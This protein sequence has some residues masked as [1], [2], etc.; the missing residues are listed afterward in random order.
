MRRITVLIFLA[1]GLPA[2]ACGENGSPLHGS[3]ASA[4][5]VR[6]ATAPSPADRITAGYPLGSGDAAV[7]VVEFSDFG[8]P[9]CGR[10]AVTTFPDLRAEYIETGRVRWRYVPV[11]FGFAGGAVMGAAAECAGR[12]AG[13]DGF[14]R[15]HDIMYRHQAALRG[16]DAL[17]RLLQWLGEAGLDAARIEACVQDPA[18]V[19]VLQANNRLAEEW[20]VR[21]TPTFVVN[22][23]PMSGAMPTS[24]FRK[25]LDT[26]LDPSGL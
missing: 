6:P 9:Y 11:S 21:G 19:Q 14:W 13:A 1:L 5:S 26:A 16:E 3:N 22:G 7:A 12:Q 2:W 4:A 25:I 15:A 18:T 17:P 20:F 8:C 10:F 24:F 23:V